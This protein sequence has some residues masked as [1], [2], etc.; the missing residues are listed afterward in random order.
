MYFKDFALRS[1]FPMQLFPNIHNS[2]STMLMDCH[3]RKKAL[4][5]FTKMFGSLKLCLKE[6]VVICSLI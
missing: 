5:K 6:S 4:G 3:M 2:K 1:F